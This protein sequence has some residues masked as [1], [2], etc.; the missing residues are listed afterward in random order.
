MSATAV[1][2]APYVDLTNPMSDYSY[3]QVQ[4][5][6]L[7][8]SNYPPPPPPDQT[9]YNGLYPTSAGAQQ[10]LEQEQLQFASL[11]TPTYPKIESGS[12]SQASSTQIQGLAHELS[13]HPG[14]GD[15]QRALEDQQRLQIQHAA[16]QLQHQASGPQ[17]SVGLTQ[18]QLAQQ[19][20]DQ[21]KASNRLRKACDSCS[22]RKV[23]CDESGPP[24]RACSALDIPCTFDRPSRRR[25]PPNRHAEAIK[26]RRL[27]EASGASTHTLSSPN[28]PT[29]A[30]QTLANISSATSGSQLTAESICPIET[31]DLLIDDFFTY[32]HP[33]CPFP[34]EP[35]F[36]EAWKRREDLNNKAFLALLAS[37]IGALV[38]SF[39]RKPK[40]HLKAHRRE[41]MFPNH[42][43]LV[44]RCQQVCAVARGPGYLESEN[45]SVYDAATSYF[46]AL[47]GTYT[48]RWRLGRLYFGECLNIIRTLGLHKSRDQA[49]TPLRPARAH[50]S[51]FG[52]NGDQSIDNITLEMGRRIFWTMFVTVK[53]IQQLGASF[54]ELVIPPP[55][56]S[57]PYPPLPAEVDDFCVYP[58]HNEPQP[59]GLLSVIAG[60]NANVRVF[61]SYNPLA[62][63]EMAWGIDAVIDWGRQKRVLH[64]SLRRCKGIMADLPTGLKIYPNVP[65]SQPN[66]NAQYSGY[67]EQNMMRDPTLTPISPAR[68]QE[69]E[70]KPEQRRNMQYEIQKANIYA[71][72]LLT[73]SYLVEK[74]FN[75]CEAHDRMRSQGQN[76]GSMPSS[77]GAGI[78]AAGI[79]GM[80]PQPPTSH[81][82]MVPEEM[83]QEREEIVRDL[84]VVLSSINQVN[85]EP[86]ADSFTM[87]IRAIASTL[88]DLPDQQK[89]QVALQAQE[90]LAAFLKILMKLERVS[91]G[92]NGQN[93]PED[94]E[95]ELRTWADLREYQLKFAQQGGLMG[96]S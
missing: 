23:K 63:M 95:A 93:Q 71:T 53:T 9:H 60:F 96:L 91:P 68:L 35:S 37:M 65:Q 25:G 21:Q 22:I 55:T 12:P 1:L 18:A 74:Y 41:H 66:G 48:F 87:K 86:N 31:L 4:N 14:L 6:M 82:D 72:S 92:T 28:S 16:Q 49:F 90:Y 64:E 42:M 46:L 94:D 83:R 47:M 88:L 17:S 32:I 75:L 34:H 85:M 79:D 81:Y 58:T 62:T 7:A 70:Q 78:T 3:W 59:P 80:V 38:A 54:G 36:R 24:C 30:A 27:E 19:Q 73:R 69:I 50:G 10:L 76:P 39:P 8:M 57:E 84:L 29:Y 33:L 15:Q 45:L 20:A 51:P 52:S 40:L 56:S 67:T 13:Q 89:G 44:T 5:W 2:C 61:C 43:S 11:N 26:R 77:P